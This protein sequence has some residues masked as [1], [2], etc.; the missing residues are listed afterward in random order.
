MLD[1][2]SLHIILKLLGIAQ[3]NKITIQGNL[4]Q[5]RGR[6]SVGQ[7]PI[8][9]Y[10][11]KITTFTK[12]SRLRMLKFVAT[13]ALPKIPYSLFITL[14][15]PDDLALNTPDERNRQRF[16]WLRH[17][18][19]HLVKQV[20]GIWRTEWVPRE[21]GKYVGELCP[22]LHLLLFESDWLD[23]SN[24]NDFWKRALGWNEYVR[25][26]IAGEKT[27]QAIADYVSKTM[28]YVSK[29]ISSLVNGAYL[30]TGRHWGKVRPELIPRFKCVEIDRPSKRQ[31]EYLKTVAKR[32]MPNWIDSGD[33]SF[34]LLGGL[35]SQEMENLIRLGI[36][37]GIGE[38]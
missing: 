11:N 4:V 3:D 33:Y 35:T 14:T 7:L 34:T 2:K 20:C 26:D 25:T 32:Q 38:Q 16:L 17:V 27:A 18:E 23:K 8:N 19:R 21:T 1:D 15:Y 6:H 29:D 24:V 28:A 36:D 12:Q 10:R 37:A 22:H 5:Y 13:I 31:W 30:H 9:K